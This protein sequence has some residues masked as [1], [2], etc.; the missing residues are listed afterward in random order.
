MTGVNTHTADASSSGWA[1]VALTAVGS[2]P[3]A[4]LAGPSGDVADDTPLTFNTTASYDP[5]VLT[6]A[7]ATMAAAGTAGGAASGGLSFSWECR[8]GCAT[9]CGLVGTMDSKEHC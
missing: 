1:E 2:A 3:V 6:A 8:W 5:D 7:A 9:A 4:V